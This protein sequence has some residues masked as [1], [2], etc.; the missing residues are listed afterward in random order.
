MK[1]GE[2]W[3]RPKPDSVIKAGDVLIASGY[4]EGEEKLEKMAL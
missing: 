4:A 1:R 3:I 2:K